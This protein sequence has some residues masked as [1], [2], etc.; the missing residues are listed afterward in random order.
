M[1]KDCYIVE[2]WMSGGSTT[3][4][5]SIEEL[6]KWLTE[7][8]PGIIHTK[9]DLSCS[10]WRDGYSI[11]VDFEPTKTWL[12][13]KLQYTNLEERFLSEVRYFNKDNSKE[14]IIDLVWYDFNKI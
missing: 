9:H 6:Y 11:V 12:G 10:V 3:D 5:G 1:S 8:L 2:P 14:S 4:L 13:W 7:E